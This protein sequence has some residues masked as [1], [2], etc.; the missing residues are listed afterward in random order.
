MK[1]TFENA[2][3]ADSIVKAARVA[4]TRGE[5]FDKAS[6]ILMSLDA[7]E[8]TVTLR[9]TDLQLFYLE[10]V[11]AIQVEGSGD[12]RFP[13]VIISSVMAKL[14]IGSGK[15]VTFEQVNN[16]VH[17]KSGSIKAKFRVMDPSYYPTWSPFD[18]NLLE[19]VPD[20]GARL[21][22][23]E[24]AAMEDGE[25]NYAGIH[26]TGTQAMATDRYRLAIVPCEAEP[27]SR[28]I[29]I[30]AGILKPV[31]GNLR[32]V[33]I[34]LDEGMFLLM[35][36]TSTQLRTRI[37]GRDYPNILGLL[38]SDWT[39]KVKVHKQ[40]L[41]EVIER[42][43]VFVANDRSPSMTFIVGKSQIAVMCADVEVGLFGETV[44]LPGQCIHPR[45]QILFT[46]RNLTDALVAAPSE[47]VELHYNPEITKLPVKVDG[48]SGYVALV[49]PRSQ[50]EVS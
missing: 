40:S 4:P 9:S 33:A 35:P 39:E 5:A 47:E 10:V 42:A 27:I 23:V 16:E 15:T 45:H 31:L 11:D 30:P 8:N 44:D 41:I 13:S 46:P 28:P 20:L 18:P 19:M 2:T 50:V 38:Q 22:Q 49:M 21:R 36:D 12:W 32:D 3:I 17:M 29:T 25:L 14:P 1:V 6:G 26:L 34:G 24:W 7:D 48:G 37:Y 43:A